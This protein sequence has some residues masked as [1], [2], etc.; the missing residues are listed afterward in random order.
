[1]A[2]KV[3]RPVVSSGS[4]LAFQVDRISWGAI[5]AGAVCAI[6]LQILFFLL[7]A[8]FGLELV[9][10]GDMSGVGWGSGLFFAITALASMFA[11][12]WIAGR[13]AGMPLLP[14]AALHG[15]VVWALVTIA[16]A[17]MGVSVT[18][19]LL[20]G[21]TQAVSTAGGAAASL[22]GN[23]AQ[24]VGGAVSSLAPNLEEAEFGDLEALIPPSVEQDVEALLGEGA[25]PEEIGQEV[26]SIA[27]EI[28]S[29]GDLQE[30]RQIVVGAGRE[31]LGN[32]GEAG[33]IFERA[34]EQLTAPEGPLGEQQFEQLQAE[35]QQRYGISEQESSEIAERWRTEFVEARDA[36]IETYRQ[37][38]DAVAQQLNDA[39]ETAAEAAQQAAAAAASAAWWTA[40]GIFLGLLA[41]GTG[42]ALGRPED[43][44]PVAGAPGI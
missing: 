38:Y 13:L 27:G 32:P 20:R 2:L 19:A 3:G 9:D 10:D 11:G 1:M 29:E 12:G 36:A 6:A 4:A 44:A 8:S 31:M 5:I 18:G 25:T 17:W 14:A 35:L 40:I 15:I 41:A 28:V 39:A 34:V 33:A 26:Q 42:A 37:T 43:T 24:A 21:A 16:V 30:A 22:A 23:A 7:S